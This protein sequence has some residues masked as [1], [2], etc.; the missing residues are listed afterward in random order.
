MHRTIRSR[1]VLLM[2]IAVT[3][4]TITLLAVFAF[5]ADDYYYSRKKVILRDAFESL[6]EADIVNLNKNNKMI[7]QYEDERLTFIICDSNFERVYVTKLEYNP[8]DAQSKIANEIAANLNSYSYKYNSKETENYISGFGMINQDE[9][10][11]YVYIYEN[12][13]IT[14]IFFSYMMWFYLVLGVFTIVAGAIISLMIASRIARPI[15]QIEQAASKAVDS[16]YSLDVEIKKS[17]RE[18]ESLKDSIN[19]ML[20]QIRIQ[21]SSLQEELTKQSEAEEDRRVFINNVSHELK[22][23]IAVISTQLEMLEMI[24]D[25][26]KQL[27]YIKS[28][29]EETQR[30]TEMIN[31]MIVM[32]AT[33]SDE[34]ELLVEKTNISELVCDTVGHYEN[35]FIKNNIELIQEYEDDCIATVNRKYI[36]QAVSNY[37]TNAIKH[38]KN[39]GKISVRVKD[40][41][42]Y[43]RVEV[44]N[45]GNPIPD[46][47]SE[48]IWEMFFSKDNVNSN[49]GMKSS[50]I[51][52][53]IVKSVVEVHK[54]FYG[55]NNKDGSVMFWFDIPKN[56][57]EYR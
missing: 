13:D 4:L 22:T 39:K 35:I 15:K 57:S 40:N 31:E 10:D 55:Y 28:I 33:K 29:E 7:S 9:Q 25:K 52:L 50:G 36:S 21:M 23:P 38:C 2:T 24:D 14:N 51:G 17:Y 16:G 53:S 12:K 3:A 54:G 8:V 19:N 44:E 32:Y 5:F 41:A 48:K 11:Y 46:E 1:A 20:S 27:K 45:D 56:L 49:N 47:Y 30:M 18:V 42:E 34:K 37:I 26:E 43:I 6:K